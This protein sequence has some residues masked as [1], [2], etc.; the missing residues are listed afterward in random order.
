MS[1]SL[2]D[3]DIAAIEERAVKALD[4]APAPWTTWL[5]TRGGT[6]GESFVRL[7]GDP[8]SDN[9]MYVRVQVG[10]ERLTSPDPRL[11]LVIDFVGHAAADVLRLS[12]EVK[13]LRSLTT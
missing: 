9:E 13:R 8:D 11:D 3:A 2:S 1:E 4:V 12:A 5:E 10:S 6:G 7:G